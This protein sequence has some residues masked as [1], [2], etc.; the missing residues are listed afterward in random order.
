MKVPYVE[1]LANH[2]GPESCG[3]YSNVLAEAL[4]KKSVG[5]LLSAEITLIRVPTLCTEGV[6][7]V[8]GRFGARRNLFAPQQVYKRISL[9][10]Q[11]PSLLYQRISLFFRKFPLY[12]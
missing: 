10:Y 1:D 5:G 12:I 8:P 4:T 7:L 9:L 3:G 6:D 2:R 11:R